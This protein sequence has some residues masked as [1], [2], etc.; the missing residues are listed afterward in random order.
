[1]GRLRWR[2]RA[3]TGMGPAVWL[4]HAMPLPSHPRQL[5]A[6]FFLHSPEP[7]FSLQCGHTVSPF[8][9]SLFCL[10]VLPTLYTTQPF[11]LPSWFPSQPFCPGLPGMA[12]GFLKRQLE[13]RFSWWKKSRS[14][15]ISCPLSTSPISHSGCHHWRSSSLYN[16]FFII[17]QLH[18]RHLLCVGPVV[19]KG[20][21]EIY[22]PD[23][24]S[25]GVGQGVWIQIDFHPNADSWFSNH[26]LLLI[27]L[28][29]LSPYFSSLSDVREPTLHS[30]TCSFP[31]TLTPLAILPPPHWWPTNLHLKHQ[32]LLWTPLIHPTLA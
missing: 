9:P 10:L 15:F 23:L 20:D 25:C 22:N 11:P 17:S 26:W 19:A 2:C 14:C 1:M 21:V 31:C 6:S 24:P 32:T 18:G 8:L 27:C 30:L 4:G 5:S 12:K 16:S 28:L 7:Y 13:D 29:L 3:R